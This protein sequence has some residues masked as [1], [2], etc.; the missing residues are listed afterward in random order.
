MLQLDLD[1]PHVRQSLGT[2]RERELVQLAGDAPD[3]MGTGMRG[4]QTTYH[5]NRSAIAHPLVEYH[6]GRAD[7]ALL[8]CD[9]YANPGEPVIVHLICPRCRNTLTINGAHKRIEIEGNVLSV[10]PFG[11]TWEK[12]EAGPHVPGLVGGGLSLCRWRVAIDRNVAKDA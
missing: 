1:D 6:P 3:P 8:E 5:L 10:E 9:V 2:S 12:P 4:Q 11:C 7:Y